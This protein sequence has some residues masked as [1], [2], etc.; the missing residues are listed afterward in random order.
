M[1]RGGGDAFGPTDHPVHPMQLRVGLGDG[2]AEIVDHGQSGVPQVVDNVAQL[3]HGPY[4]RDHGHGQHGHGGQADH[5]HDH[6]S[7][8]DSA[9]PAKIPPTDRAPAQQEGMTPPG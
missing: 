1:V 7:Q 9:H 5:S 8:V 6:G 3:P 2:G 4:Q